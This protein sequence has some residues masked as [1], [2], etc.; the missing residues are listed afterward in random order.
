MKFQISIHFIPYDIS[1]CLG[2]QTLDRAFAPSGD[3]E[4]KSQTSKTPPDH[5]DLHEMKKRNRIQ[6]GDGFR[7]D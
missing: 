5:L 1:W 4:S 3:R 6:K 2:H 7:K